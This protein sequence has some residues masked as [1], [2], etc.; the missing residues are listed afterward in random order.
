MSEIANE[1]QL[2][3]QGEELDDF[4][5]EGHG[6][7]EVALGLSAA[8]IVAGGAG[9]AAL[10]MDNP[11]PG[12]TSGAQRVV[13][14]AQHDVENRRLWAE[15]VGADALRTAGDTAGDVT[16][17]ADRTV[18]WAGST[19]TRTTAPVVAQVDAAAAAALDLADRTVADATG[20]ATETAADP[21]GTT[22]RI[23]DE[24]MVVARDTRDGAAGTAN[25]A[26]TTA[27]K[28]VGD[29]ATTAGQA[30]GD[31]AELATTTAGDVQAIADP[32]A[33]VEMDDEKTTVQAGAAGTTVTVSTG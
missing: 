23:V 19:A 21:I 16:R 28:A 6:L 29:T 9:A 31:A 13:A 33:D 24:T 20:L 17:G 1:E 14:G 22:D 26:V 10:A 32:R 18:T 25:Q 7:K 5:V 15:R 12:T 30:V 2:A 27:E 3:T 11:L 4:D 8:T